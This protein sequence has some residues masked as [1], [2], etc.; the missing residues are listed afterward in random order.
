MNILHVI[1]QTGSMPI[2][3]QQNNKSPAWGIF[4]GQVFYPLL[5]RYGETSLITELLSLSL[6]GSAMTAAIQF[7]W[8]YYLLDC[9]AY[10]RNDKKELVDNDVFLLE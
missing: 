7:V 5:L 10:A 6:R 1:R 8:L 2:H 4:S 3:G 9:H